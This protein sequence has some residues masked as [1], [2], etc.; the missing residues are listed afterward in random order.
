MF[1]KRCIKPL[2]S[3]ISIWEKEYTFS[4]TSKLRL[5]V[6]WKDHINLLGYAIRMLRV[7]PSNLKSIGAVCLTCVH[8]GCPLAHG[9]HLNF[10]G[11][12]F[13]LIAPEVFQV[14]LVGAFWY[15]I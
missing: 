11:G 9:L 7:K 6:L 3:P 14:C 12:D 10:V 15:N 13:S 5:V 8:S 4:M 1:V 2:F